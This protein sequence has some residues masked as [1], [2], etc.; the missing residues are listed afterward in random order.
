MRTSSLAI[1]GILLALGCGS[2]AETPSSAPPPPS[3]AAPPSS[4]AAAPPSAPG[5]S[6]NVLLDADGALATAD[7]RMG[8]MYVDRYTFHADT[9][10]RVRVTVTSPTLDTVLRVGLP[11]AGQGTLT[12]D[13]VA[14]DRTRSEVDFVAAAAGD[15]K[16]SVTSFAPGATGPY[17][18]HA[19]HLMDAPNVAIA[20]APQFHVLPGNFRSYIAGAT[21]SAPTAEPT[22][23]TVHVGDHVQGTLATGDATL[24]SGEFADYYSFAATPGRY[25]IA[26]QST[27]LDSFV[28]VT[29][30]SGER[31]QNDD[32][33]GSRDASL[34]IDVPAAGEYRIAAT[35]YRAGESGAYALSVTPTAA[36]GVTTV[37]APS[38]PPSSA[39]GAPP[40]VRT[41]HGTLANGDSQLSSGEFFDEYDYTFTQGTPVHLEATS[42]AF[43]T[44]LILRSPD[45]Q[46]QDNDDQAPGVLNAA[47]DF[48]ASQSGQYRVLVT[49]YAPGMTG[50]YDLTVNGNAS[51]A[52][53]APP[54]SGPAAPPGDPTAAPTGP[55]AAPGDA[56]RVWVV[57][58]GIT[59]YPD[60]ANHLPECANDARKIVEALHNQ[61]LSTTD[62]EFLLVD[63][64]AT[65]EGIHHAIQQVAQRIGP[66]DTFVFFWSGHG[67]QATATTTDPNE[68]DGHDEFIFVY[69]GEIIDDQMAQ[70]MDQVHA[71]SLFSL[72]SCFSGG[73]AKD[74]VHRPGI[75]GM[76]S[77]E[78][79]VTSAVA[80]QFQAGG[81]L[82][83]FLRLGMQ[84]NADD[85]PHDTTTTVGELTHYVWQQWAQHATDVRMSGG[86]Q[87]LV[88]E[89]GSVHTDQIFW[90]LTGAGATRGSSAPAR[91]RGGRTR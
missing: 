9:G 68:L 78:E 74:V 54:S 43:D 23:V 48:T 33:G 79:D 53:S 24:P 71:L 83:H 60:A 39:A 29:T 41:E 42:S 85:D 76:F 8:N 4:V 50:A 59:N 45:G 10:Q 30:P 14:G 86:Y 35:S 44:Y 47:L 77:S 18:V 65:V 20:A 89:R 61:G 49:S 70:W 81:Y 34:D 62:T 5:A 2:S 1:L 31:L 56:T 21:P 82:S 15:V 55:V 57:S 88:E 27:R 25:T 64:Q 32:S 22:A 90:R 73:F 63:N 19:E 7:G 52:P 84:G 38:A 3:S 11:G 58:A 12:N 80:L 6:G 51:G 72:D 17:H 13:D 40:G 16:V 28:V 67:G 91:P 26:M 66:N 36:G 87:Q 69:D 37:A 75:V 46:Q